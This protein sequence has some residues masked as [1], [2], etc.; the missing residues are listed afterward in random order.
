MLR[1]E[2][3]GRVVGLSLKVPRWR[4]LLKVPRDVC[5]RCRHFFDEQRCNE[6]TQRLSQSAAVRFRRG[7]GK[8]HP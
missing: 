4:R 5:A 1:R 6:P 2:G 3:D 8:H 7:S